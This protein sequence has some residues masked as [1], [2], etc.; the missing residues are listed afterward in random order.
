MG[1]KLTKEE[2]IKKGRS[3]HGDKYGYDKVE[4]Y[5]VHTKVCIICPE[6]GEFWQVPS[7]HLSGKG[8][9]KCGRS[10][11]ADSKRSSKEEFIKNANEIHKGKYNYDKVEYKGA[12]TKV[13]IICPNP[14]HGEF[15]QTPNSHMKGCG[16]PKCGVLTN[17]DSRR[18]SKEEFIKRAN[19]KHDGKYDYSKVDY[20]GAKTKVCIICPEH[21]EFWQTPNEHKKGCGCPKCGNKAKGDSKRSSK[22]DFIKKSRQVHKDKYDYSKVDY[23]NSNTKVCIICKEHGEFWQTPSHHVKGMGCQKC[24]QISIAN[25]K[26]S[27][28][29]NFIKKAHEKHKNRYDYSKVE[30]VNNNTKVCIICTKHGEF[31]QVPSSHL[32]GCGCPKC[33]NEKIRERK[34]LSKEEFIQK[35]NEVH[36]DKYGYSKVDYVD[37][38]TKVCIICKEH[39]EFWQI[40]NSHIRGCGCPKCANEANGER[41]RSSLSDFITSACSV[42]GNKYKYSKVEYI[43]AI[44]KVCIICPEHGEFWQTPI[45][46]TQGY[47]CPKCSGKHVPTTEEWITSAH[48]VHGNR[49]D[50]SKVDYVNCDTKVCIICPEHGEFKQTPDSHIRGRGCPKC[51]NIVIGDKLRL[52]LLDFIYF[53]RKKHGEKY[54]YSKVDYVNNRT[55]ICIVCPEHGEFW[56]TPSSHTQGCGCPKCNLSHLERN[57]IQCL[58]E[59]GITYDYQKRFDWLG[60]QSLDFYLPDYNV[61]IECQGVQH[62]EPVERFGGDKEFKNI[63]GRDKRKFKKCDKHGIKLLYYSNLGIDYPYTVFEDL[64]LLFEEIKKHTFISVCKNYNSTSYYKR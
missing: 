18:L 6:H 23:V 10:K 56:Q 24:G 20:V 38:Q 58:D 25:S 57:V 34:T 21:G 52:S 55:K 13:C 41:C 26:R 30:Y 39:G 36:K 60:K 48:E 4:Y 51:G 53:A 35:A 27:S 14:E 64:D 7:G 54:D 40:P 32:S 50:Y 19:E 44:T 8:C 16:C 29:S 11:T 43:N 46:H 31:W 59:H 49:Y 45:G 28:L 17:G 42:H 61:G 5:G 62:F 15:W 1:K 33:A 9:S 37:S 47:G 3:V 22:S 12:H 2:F 63:L